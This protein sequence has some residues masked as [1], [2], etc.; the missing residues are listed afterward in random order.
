MRELVLDTET[1]GLDPSSGHRLVELAAIEIVNGVYTGRDYWR[2]YNPERDMPPDAE[3]IHGLSSDFLADKPRF[4]DLVDEMLEFLG[5]APL[6][7]H[8]AEFDMR[9]LNAELQR[10]GRPVLAAG[11]A[12][13]TWQMAK[14]KFPGSPVSLDALCKRFV[15]DNTHRTKHGAL[16]DAR[17]LADVY[18]ELQGGRQRGLELA[19]SLAEAAPV[20]I[21]RVARPAR[22]HA[23]TEAE[24]AA[25]AALMARLK[26]PV[27]LSA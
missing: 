16:L 5:D 24:L 22:P 6:V 26:N 20:A 27:W 13:C 11:R 8:N 25:H 15:I 23:P 10:C 3:A 18:V 21:T 2:Y 14:K 9:F 7:I 1:T 4:A 17:L 12:T 19:A